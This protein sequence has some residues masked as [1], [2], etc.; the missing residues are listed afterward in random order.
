MRLADSN[1]P[2]DMQGIAGPWIAWNRDR[3]RIV[4]SG[5]TFDEVKSRA[6]AAGEAQVVLARVSELERPRG[7]GRKLLYM[8]TAFLSL[9]SSVPDAQPAAAATSGGAAAVDSS[10]VDGDDDQ[11]TSDQQVSREAR[12]RFGRP[13]V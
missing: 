10:L 3:T 4:A 2:L 7:R 13:S 9:A 11:D 5:T 1:Q 6:A 12:Q 8:V